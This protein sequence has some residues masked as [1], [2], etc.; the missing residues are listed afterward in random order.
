MK[1]TV[2]LNGYRR[3]QALQ[4]QYDAIKNQTYKNI[5]IMFWSN[6]YEDMQDKFSNQIL[7][8]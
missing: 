5:D 3:P 6:Y 2:I 1:I 4:E 7:S 8:N